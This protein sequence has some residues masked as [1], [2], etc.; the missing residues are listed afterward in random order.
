MCAFLLE[1]ISIVRFENL[2][3]KDRLQIHL[4]LKAERSDVVT[5]GDLIGISMSN[6]NK[7]ILKM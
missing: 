2:Y 5:N 4:I 3:L 6:G 1:Y 7:N